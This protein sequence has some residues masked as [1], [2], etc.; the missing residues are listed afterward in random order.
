M[1]C[2]TFSNAA[3]KMTCPT[4]LPIFSSSISCRSWFCSLDADPTKSII[5]S[6]TSSL[7]APSLWIY[8]SLWRTL[9]RGRY[10]FCKAIFVA[11]DRAKAFPLLK[12]AGTLC[13]YGTY[14][15]DWQFN[16]VRVFF[17]Q[18]IG[19]SLKAKPL[20]HHWFCCTHCG[21]GAQQKLQKNLSRV[22]KM[23][24]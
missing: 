20:P 15:P 7:P 12:E 24:K 2:C 18:Y 21:P 1:T 16:S 22:K 5:T 3:C 9:S 17:Y 10:S 19:D 4:W 13:Y 8:C 6:Q 23:D 14:H 11:W